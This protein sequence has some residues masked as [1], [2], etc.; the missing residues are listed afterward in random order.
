MLVKWESKQKLACFL[1]MVFNRSSQKLKGRSLQKYSSNIR[2]L[3]AAP[4]FYGVLLL[5]INSLLGFIS[6]SHPP[7]SMAARDAGAA[8][9]VPVL[10]AMAWWGYRINVVKAARYLAAVIS[11][12]R[13]NSLARI[14]SWITR[15]L[16]SRVEQV[17]WALVMA[18]LI[19]SSAYLI[20]QG[21]TD[22]LSEQPIRIILL[23]QAFPLWLSILHVLTANVLTLKFLRK[24]LNQYFRVRL[25]EI[26]RLRPVCHLVV[27]NFLVASLLLTIFGLNALFIT[28]PLAD[29]L[30][31]LVFS[32]V[33]LL[34]LIQPVIEMSKIVSARREM[35]LSRIND[36]LKVQ[37]DTASAPQKDDRR[38]VDNTERLQFI[39]DLLTVR[40]EISNAPVWP[41]NFP[42]T[43]K[44]LALMILPLV[45]WTGSG[46]VAQLMKQV[47]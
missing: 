18:A 8:F 23:M 14:Q 33:I 47:M 26:E 43:I 16:V 24:H 29:A 21:I 22:T 34:I 35:T 39:S 3:A 36:T 38:L 25:F 31:M 9:V 12:R 13:R 20:S 46:V 45:S 19:L 15:L 6:F 41:M 11:H 2:Q 17:R 1:T 10:T 42:S 40:K 30:L 7:D 28:L 44:I 37:L 27:T 5:V 32:L 4:V